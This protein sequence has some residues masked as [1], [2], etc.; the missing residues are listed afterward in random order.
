MVNAAHNAQT[1]ALS[2]HM[3]RRFKNIERDSAHQS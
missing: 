2:E 3:L 1:I